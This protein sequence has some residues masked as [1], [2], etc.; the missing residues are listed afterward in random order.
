MKP[1]VENTI[2]EEDVQWGERYTKNDGGRCGEDEMDVGVNVR[3][4]L[5][6]SPAPCSP[7]ANLQCNKNSFF[8]LLFFFKQLGRLREVFTLIACPRRLQGRFSPKDL[9][10]FLFSCFLTSLGHRRR[11]FQPNDGTQ[12]PHGGLHLSPYFFSFFFSEWVKWKLRRAPL[13]SMFYSN[14]Q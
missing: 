11:G 2:L 9:V 12:A 3:V 7:P 1:P 5:A 14:L 13:P 4:P 6:P 10:L 8:P